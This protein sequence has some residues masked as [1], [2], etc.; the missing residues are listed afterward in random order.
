MKAIHKNPSI[1]VYVS[2]CILAQIYTGKYE[3]MIK[4]FQNLP[5]DISESFPD[6][7][8]TCGIEYDQVVIRKL[9]LDVIDGFEVDK[10]V[11]LRIIV[12]VWQLDPE[13]M[14]SQV[15]GSDQTLLDMSL[16]RLL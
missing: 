3:E 1:A 9:L 6:I 14:E 8:P 13:L 4:E 7:L 5:R 10:L 16:K 2:S 11:N 12:A 15:A